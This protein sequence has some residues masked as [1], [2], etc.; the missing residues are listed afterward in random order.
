M[1][2]LPILVLGITFVLA[3]PVGLFMTQVFEGKCRIPDWLRWIESRL[4]T[5]PQNWKQ[6]CVAF[7]LCNLV[8]F[9]GGFAILTCQPYLPLNP[10]GK[11]MLSPTMIFHTV[12]SF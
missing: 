7:M 11:G 10:D 6:Y 9:L 1:W 12:V 2:T 5:G 4:D 8:T 3:I